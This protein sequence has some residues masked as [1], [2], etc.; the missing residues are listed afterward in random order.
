M[1]CT[2]SALP[3]WVS[4]ALGASALIAAELFFSPHAIKSQTVSFYRKPA[5]SSHSEARPFQDRLGVWI[6]IRDECCDVIMSG[7][8]GGGM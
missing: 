6:T 8:P 5:A 3:R 7:V 2:R 1:P 4:P